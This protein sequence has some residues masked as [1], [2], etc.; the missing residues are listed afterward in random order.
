M[1]TIMDHFR[2]IYAA[3]AGEY[4]RMI[5]AEDVDHNLEKALLPI[6]AP[7]SGKRLVDLGTGTGRIPWLLAAQA[8]EVIGLDDQQAMLAENGHLRQQMGGRWHL[9]QADMSDVPLPDACTDVVTAGWAIGH[10]CAWYPQDWRSR[11]EKVI[12]EMH[13]LA[14]PGGCIIVLETMSTGSEMPSPPTRELDEYYHLLS[15]KFGFHI[16]II[17]TD[18][19]FS[20]VEDAVAHTRFFFGEELADTIRRRS[21][22]RLPEWT[23][24]WWK[25][26]AIES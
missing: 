21:W 16:Q 8:G 23:G 13:R 22:M 6:I 3:R 5:A 12:I 1:G 19:L 17:Q 4:Q 25:Y 7:L 2:A 14:K 9:I 18:Y 26:L 20:S 11:I 10:F 24:I 15:S